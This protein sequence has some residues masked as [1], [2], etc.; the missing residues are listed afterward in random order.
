M[1]TERVG[2]VDVVVE[3]NLREIS[4][5]RIPANPR[6]RFEYR[7]ARDLELEHLAKCQ[8]IGGGRY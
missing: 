7:S 3:G 1:K 2:D 4:L 6:A 5:A 8:R